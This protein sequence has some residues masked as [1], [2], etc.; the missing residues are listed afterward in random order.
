[1]GNNLT[2]ILLA[3]FIAIVGGTIL[4]SIEVQDLL[5]LPLDIAAGVGYFF[6]LCLVGFLYFIQ[7]KSM[8]GNE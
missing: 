3:F 1:V 6:V 7:G 5:S 4:L 8:E 2:S